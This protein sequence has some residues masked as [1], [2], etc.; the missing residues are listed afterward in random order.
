MGRRGKGWAE[1]GRGGGGGGGGRAE[2]RGGGEGC[3]SHSPTLITL[4]VVQPEQVVQALAPALLPLLVTEV[5][6]VRED[7]EE[8][9]ETVQLAHPILQGGP[10]E[11]PLVAAVKGKDSL[12][13]A[14]TPV[15]DAVGLIQNDSPPRHLHISCVFY[16]WERSKAQPWRF[17]LYFRTRVSMRKV[18]IL[19]EK[20][21]FVISE[22]PVSINL[23]AFGGHTQFTF[24]LLSV[25]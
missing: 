21:L 25:H 6:R 23:F 22:K 12:G 4:A 9:N 2:R 18:K 16:T 7:P 13:C 5:V 19:E 24:C 20:L 8:S 14:G 10:T 17:L 3:M 1:G 15:L 11:G